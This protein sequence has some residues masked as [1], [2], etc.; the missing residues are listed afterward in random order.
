MVNRTG[1]QIRIPRID[2]AQPARMGDVPRVQYATNSGETGAGGRA[3]QNLGDVLSHISTRIED[4]LDV[5]ASVDAAREGGIAGS[6]GVPVRQDDTTIRGR[7]FNSAAR[8]S[9]AIQ[10]DLDVRKALTQYETEHMADP[11]AFRQKANSYLS[12]R[13]PGIASFDPVL[14]KRMEGEFAQRVSSMEGQ[15]RDRQVAI[16][17]DQQMEQATRLQLQVQDDL[18]ADAGRLFSAGAQETQQIMARMMGNAAKIIDTSN[19]LGPDGRPLFSGS[20]RAQAEYDARRGVSEKIAMAYVQA[21]PNPAQALEDIGNGTA[22]FDMADDKGNV[23]KTNLRQIIGDADMDALLPDITEKTLRNLRQAEAIDAA[24]SEEARS[25]FELQIAQTDDPAALDKMMRDIDLRR[26]AFGGTMYANDLKQ[27]ILTKNRAYREKTESATRGSAF[28]SGTAY[29]NT[30]NS[31]SVKDFNAAYDSMV[32][33][34][35]AQMDAPS[36]NTLLANVIDRARAVPETLKG[37]IKAAARSRNVE[38]VAAAADLID[39]VR[40]INPN[41]LGDLGSDKE[42]ARIDMVR[43][44][45]DAG[46]NEQEAVEKADKIFDPVNASMVTARKQEL[47]AMKMDYR[48]AAVAAL[49]PSLLYRALPGD[50]GADFDAPTATPAQEMQLSEDYR[51]AYETQYALT[52]N[53]YLAEKHAKS[54][55]KGTYAVTNI[56]GRKSIMKYAPEN[57]YAISGSRNEWMRA[58]VLAEA[59]K[60]TAPD[61]SWMPAD[62]NLKEDVLLVPDPYVTPRTAKAGRPVYK[63]MYR[64]RSDGTIRDLLGPNQYFSFDP[65]KEK[66]AL[67][68]AARNRNDDLERVGAWPYGANSFPLG[69]Q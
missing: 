35:L 27:K 20:A 5:Q 4:R 23:T 56:N 2:P 62:F 7:A 64:S 37:D 14:A 13:M 16:I 39:R 47:T 52:G 67:V 69:G 25:N 10:T 43:S 8:D 41:M 32:S 12:G 34:R 29:L 49:N 65:D 33:P 57:Y 68:D 40:D 63:L 31:Q 24:R 21:S 6:N 30:E 17:R 22:V 36:R 15:I 19:T 28:L 54:F 48:K 11:A 58:Q 18:D 42:L 3:L 9:L 50:Q 51:R 55:I 59:R 26:E 45:R 53:E 38:E 46:Y 61:K 1:Q 60:V 44:Y 66:A